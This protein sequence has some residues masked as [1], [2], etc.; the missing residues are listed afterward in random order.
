MSRFHKSS[1][2]P[3]H[4]VPGHVGANVTP[5]HLAPRPGSS[6]PVHAGMPG[7]AEE[8]GEPAMS[9]G[10]DMAEESDEGAPPPMPSRHKRP[11]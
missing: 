8:Q 11:Y 6:A 9:P 1:H 10:A 5:Q 4:P 2:S 3:M 7:G